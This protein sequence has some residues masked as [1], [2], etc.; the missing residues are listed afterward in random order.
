MAA[1]D[2]EKEP[3]TREPSTLGSNSRALHEFTENVTAHGI[4]KVIYL[5]KERSARKLVSCHLA[6]ASASARKDLLPS[7]CT[8]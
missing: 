3:L 8:A 2:H 6:N 5:S 7:S 1:S 4:S